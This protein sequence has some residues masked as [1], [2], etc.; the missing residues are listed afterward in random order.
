MKFCFLFR[1]C[2][3]RFRET[4]LARGGTVSMRELFR[5]FR[6]RDPNYE[7]YTQRLTTQF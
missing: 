6:A 2:I 4:I 5:Q 7:H 3:S 1:F